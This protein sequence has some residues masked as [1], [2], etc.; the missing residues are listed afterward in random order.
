[1]IK[2]Y[3]RKLILEDGQEYLGYS[4]GAEGERICEIVFNT[5][6]TGYQEILTDPSYT[7]QAVVM[8]YPLIG[9]YGMTREDSES[10]GAG[11]DGLIVREYEDGMYN[12][13]GF[14]TA[15]AQMKAQGIVGIA[16][17]DTRA[18]TRSIRDGGSRKVLITHSGVS[19]QEGLA[20]LEK[21]DLPAD[22][23]SR[24]SC[25]KITV[26]RPDAEG[27]HVV[28]IDC[29]MKKS[30]VRDLLERGCRVSIV[31]WNTSAA[32]IDALSPDG[33][34]ISNGPGDPEMVPETVRTVRKLTGRCPILGICLGHQILALAYGARIR[35]LKFGHHGG[36]HPVLELDTGRIGMTAQNHS[37]AADEQSLKDT[38]LSVTHKNLLDNTVEGVKCER[39]RAYGIQFHP[40]GAPGPLDQAWLF[41]R[42]MEEMKNARKT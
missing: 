6:M 11:A 34:L 9:I 8:T 42:F 30:I 32:Q 24:V 16:G 21:T 5:S 28:L 26:C 15:D 35:K 17:I 14:Q 18:L 29:G 23:V 2:A 19:L 33:V 27:P 39:D 4:F 13:R 20:I 37:Y 25:R 10:D 12:F 7:G 38:V 36:N 31:P 40:E 41:D 22:T 1:M 3:D